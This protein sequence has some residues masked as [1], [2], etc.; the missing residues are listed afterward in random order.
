MAEPGL[1]LWRLAMARAVA[2]RAQQEWLAL[3]P[4][5]L[6]GPRPEG[7]AARPRDLRPADPHLGQAL[8]AGVYSFAGETLSTR[9]RLDPWR[10]ASPS[11]A[12]AVRL[13]RFDWLGDMLAAGDPGLRAALAVSLEWIQVFGR[14]NA[15]AWSAEVM[16][17]RVF[18]LACAGRDL[19]AAA[20]DL[21]IAA[22]ARTLS[23]QARG[24]LRSHDAPHR[25]AERCCAA[26]CAGTALAGRAGERL[27]S[28]ALRQLESALETTVTPDGVHASRS[29]EAGLELLLD[30]LTLDDALSQRGRPP[31]EGLS[32]AIDR[33]TAGLRFF[34]LADGRLASFQG[35]EESF[36][37]RIAAARAHDP[38]AGQAEPARE[39]RHGGYQRLAGRAIT[40]IADAGAPA[41]G[42]FSLTAC[43]QP[44]ALEILCGRDR[45]ITG[46]GWSALALGPSALRL[47]GG[48][49]TAAVGD[50]EA[51]TPLKGFLARALG[52][53]LIGGAVKVEASRRENDDGVWLEITH[54]GWLPRAHLTHERRLYLDKAQ[55]EL[56]GEDR[57]MPAEGAGTQMLPISIHFHLH[58]DVR[59]SLARD[60]RSV[61]LRGPSNVGWWL[62]NDAGEVG[63]EA[64]VS[65]LGGAPRRTTQV[66]LRGR[67]R[68]D[69]GGR[70]RWKL[71]MVEGG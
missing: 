52:P 46:C 26:A 44:A 40:V 45:L 31:S 7:F 27:T 66:V 16:E 11:R 19:A 39:A 24:L 30:L 50:G 33:L 9:P 36:A 70:I 64:S 5:A 69:R 38:D 32:R 48:A 37:A 67:L 28:D 56:R 63:V 62:R 13:H 41:Q 55:D 14:W 21:E 61:L 59:A 58:P 4:G 29:P 3:V 23:R 71:S 12:F 6:D 10:Q 15:F 53:R 68:A 34:T 47:A 65:F 18:N 43:G 60:Q 8:L 54:D 17:R 49:S 42:D 35:G 1:G 22:L 51:G 20:S 25:L 2:R 57:F